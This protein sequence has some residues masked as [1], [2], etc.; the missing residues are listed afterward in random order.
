MHDLTGLSNKYCEIFPVQRVESMGIDNGQW[1]HAIPEL[2]IGNDIRIKAEPA[3]TFSGIPVNVTEKTQ[4][5]A[6][7]PVVQCLGNFT[8]L[9]LPYPR[10]RV[11]RNASQSILLVL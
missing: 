7:N 3:A 9:K 10:I 2:V 11:T 8:D 6:V 4:N 5:H 1:V